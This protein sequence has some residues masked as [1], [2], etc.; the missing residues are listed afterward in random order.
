MLKE[1]LIEPHWVCIGQILKPITHIDDNGNIIR[2]E[3]NDLEPESYLAVYYC[4]L[5]A[6]PEDCNTYLFISMPDITVDTSL[7]L[8]AAEG[9]FT[10]A[11]QLPDQYNCDLFFGYVTDY[12]ES[13]L[14]SKAPERVAYSTAVIS[15]Y[16]LMLNKKNYL[17]NSL[18]GLNI[19]NGSMKLILPE[20]SA[21]KLLSLRCNTSEIFDIGSPS[22]Y[23]DRSLSSSPNLQYSHISRNFVRLRRTIKEYLA[24]RKFTLNTLFNAQSAVNYIRTDILDSFVDAGILTKYDISYTLERQTVKIHIKLLFYGIAQSLNL[25]FII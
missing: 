13:T 4:L 25:D 10:E 8:L 11:Y 9:E 5:E 16:N 21:Y 18:D 14:Y 3:I 15:L 1:S 22:I 19:S 24:T 17:T 7:R 20:A 2:I 12:I 23:G 6:Y